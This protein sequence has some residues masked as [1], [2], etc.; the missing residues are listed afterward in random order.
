MSNKLIEQASFLLGRMTQYQ[1]NEEADGPDSTTD[2]IPKG[3]SQNEH[4]FLFH[5]SSPVDKTSG[6]LNEATVL[7]VNK[8][9]KPRLPTNMIKSQ[10]MIDVAD[11]ERLGHN[12][13]LHKRIGLGM[14]SELAKMEKETPQE[15]REKLKQSK[16]V[17][18]DF[19]R[20][21]G[22][23]AGTAPK[24]LRGNMKTEKSSGE[25]VLTTGLNLAPHA[26][27][28]LNN[29]D[30]CPNASQ[31]CRANCLGTTAGGNKQYPDTA[32]SSKI[33]RTHFIA[34][35]PEHAVRLID[36]EISAHTRKAKRMRMIPG[37]RL[38]ITSDIAWEHHAPQLFTRHPKVQFYDYT[39]SPNRVMKHLDPKSGH[40][41]NYHLT[42]SHT[43]TGHSESNDKDVGRVLRAGGV[44]ASVFK[45]GQGRKL[46]THVIDHS[47]GKKYPVVNGDEDDN[48][49]DRHATAGLTEGRPGSGV[50]SGLMLKGVKNEDAGHFA[51][52]VD[53]HG[54]ANINKGS[55]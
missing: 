34:A 51:N 14:R 43:G 36:S 37:V 52:D 12:E 40:P 2:E 53:Q 49:F 21:R 4:D 39:K 29:F 15:S 42:L 3:M 6:A 27:S 9:I 19:A 38:N 23:K 18:R 25:G 50:V 11:S 41:K 54:I 7:D 32:L 44:V 31:E 22:L 17:L 8:G 33:L 35:H 16:Q 28:G 20:S 10:H 5:L 1:L 55:K 45:R 13:N 46:P 30:V 26:T 47:T 24:M 48:T